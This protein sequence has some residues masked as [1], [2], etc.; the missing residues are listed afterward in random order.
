MIETATLLML[1]VGGSDNA[2][3]TMHSIGFESMALCRAAELRVHAAFDGVRTRRNSRDANE[4]GH[5]ILW[6]PL[7]SVCIEKAHP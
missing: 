5:P 4:V 1:L 7:I 2:A 6:K 3:E